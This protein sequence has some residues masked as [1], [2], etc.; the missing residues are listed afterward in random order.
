MAHLYPAHK[1]KTLTRFS[2]KKL[3]STSNIINI[4]NQYCCYFVSQ[5]D[6]DDI[7]GHDGRVP[8][9]FPRG[10]SDKGKDNK[11]YGEFY[12]V[13]IK[14]WTWIY[15]IKYKSV[16]LFSKETNIGNATISIQQQITILL[17]IKPQTI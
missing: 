9:Q 1:H 16:W 8:T 5:P 3:C 7:E 10:K 6:Y 13:V 4:C 15:R 17:L 2:S 14:S 12:N 11:K